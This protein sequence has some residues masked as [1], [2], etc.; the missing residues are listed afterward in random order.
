MLD[1]RRGQRVGSTR[2]L[3][4]RSANASQRALAACTSSGHRQADHS[5]CTNLGRGS[6]NVPSTAASIASCTRSARLWACSHARCTETS[7]MFNVPPQQTGEHGPVRPQATMSEVAWPRITSGCAGTTKSGCGVS[8]AAIR[9]AS[10]NLASL[11]AVGLER[12]GHGSGAWQPS[13]RCRYVSSAIDRP[14]TCRAL[15]KIQQLSCARLLPCSCA[16]AGRGRPWS[17]RRLVH[18]VPSNHLLLS[19]VR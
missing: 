10:R 5:H 12:L 4:T 16:G 2:S 8:G 9:A 14:G 19:G 3:L 7:P 18:H 13:Y 17:S 11:A 1:K 6:G 15:E